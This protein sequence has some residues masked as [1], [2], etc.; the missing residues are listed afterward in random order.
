TPTATGAPRQSGGEE[1]PRPHRQAPGESRGGDLRRRPAPA[2][3]RLPP[4]RSSTLQTQSSASSGAPPPQ[5]PAL[6]L[7]PLLLAFLHRRA[8]A[9]RP[10]LHLPL[11]GHR[12]DRPGRQPELHPAHPAALPPRSRPSTLPPPGSAPNSLPHPRAGSPPADCGADAP[13]KGFGSPGDGDWPEIQ[14]RAPEVKSA[15]LDREE[16][17][18]GRWNSIMASLGVSPGQDCP[19]RPLKSR[20]G[21][22]F[23]YPIQLDGQGPQREARDVPRKSSLSPPFG[24]PSPSALSPECVAPLTSA[25]PQLNLKQAIKLQFEGPTSAAIYKRETPL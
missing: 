16:R 25:D 22:L 15:G 18:Q 24:F 2:L 6:H 1:G 17:R 13:R 12:A 14:P 21:P 10:V 7:L 5:G 20:D 4:S 3:P 11:P 19:S 9:L 23:G 8:P